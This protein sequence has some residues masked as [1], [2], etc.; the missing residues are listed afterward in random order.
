MNSNIYKSTVF[1]M[2]CLQFDRAA[3]ILQMDHRLRER[4]KTPKRCMIVSCPIELDTGE[5]VVYEGFRVQH[6]LS[7]GPTK[8]GLR[9]HPKV[10]LGEVAALAMWMSWKCAL[11]D[12]PYGG[13]KGG[14][15][16]DPHTL[17]ANELEHLSRRYMQEM[18]PFVGT[19]VDVMAPDMG[20]NE[21]IMAWMMDT[22]SSYVGS[23]APAIVT[24]KPIGAGGSEGRREAT[25]RGAAYLARTYMQDLGIA[26]Q[27]ATVIIQGFGNVGSEAAKAFVEYGTKVIGISDVSGAF[28]N[29]K[30]L[31]IEDALEH[32]AKNRSL[33]GWNG[34]DSLSNE[35]LLEQPCDL[36]MPAALERVIHAENASKIQC[37]ILCEAANGPTTNEADA[38]LLERGDVLVIPDVLCNSGGVIVSYFEWVQDLQ[39][40]FWTRDEV[41]SKLYVILERAKTKVEKQKQRYGCSRREAALS[42]GISKVAEAKRLRGLFP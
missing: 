13:A 32:V 37:R 10:D 33:A 22:Y 20:T 26:P 25:G 42:L 19:N 30:G 17:S 5:I 41:L 9:F 14:I 7:M 8:G 4:V 18:I 6:H 3:D 2:A 27:S 12:L 34:G 40:T 36:L 28:F 21:Q 29:P 23:S 11:V 39:S 35:E 38:I 15:A 1:D 24:G 31:D 16:V